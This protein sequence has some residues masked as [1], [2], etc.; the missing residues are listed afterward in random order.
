[1]ASLTRRS[2]VKAG[3]LL[4]LMA[5]FPRLVMARAGKILNDACGLNPTNVHKHIIVKD[6]SDKQL[7]ALLRRELKAAAVEEASGSL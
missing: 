5:V 2:F 4:S 6:D 1:M 7:I 3:A